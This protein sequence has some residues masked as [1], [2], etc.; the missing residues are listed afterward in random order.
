MNKIAAL[1]LLCTAIFAQQ[2]GTFTDTRDGK[3]YKTVKICEQVWMAENL[4]YNASGSRCYKDNA[5]YCNKYGRLY[6]WE[7]ANTVCPKGWHLPRYNEWEALT[8]AVGGEKTEG[9]YLKSTSGWNNAEGESG[10]GEDKFGFSALPGG[11]Y[12]ANWL[13]CHL[14]GGNNCET[15]PYSKEF[16]RIGDFGLWWCSTEHGKKSA[17][18]KMMVHCSEESNLNGYDKN[19]W[20]SVR[21]IQDTPA[22]IK[23]PEPEFTKDTITDVRDGKVYKTVKIGK[24]VWFA[25]NLNYMVGGSKCYN[26]GGKIW[27]K[28]DVL[29]KVSPDKVQANCDKYGRLYNWY[30]AL[31]LCPSGWHL[32]SKREWDI[33]Y[34]YADGT[35]HALASDTSSSCPYES[36]TAE[37]YLKATSGWKDDDGVSGN[38]DDRYGFSALPGGYNYRTKKFAGDGYFGEWWSST[39]YDSKNAHKRKISSGHGKRY[40]SKDKTSKKLLFSVRCIQDSTHPLLPYNK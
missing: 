1:L 18:F 19:N 6:D 22:Q 7:T 12:G 26:E 30:M 35:I 23:M 4:N 32:P 3:K 27:D 24:Q 16:N 39:E 8:D 29:I 5:T 10:N 11:S 37:E 2:K 38:G 20:F 15:D 31:R 9:K 28:N 36:Q 17:Y 40:V 21:C 34:R 13:R 33:L 14:P 25:E